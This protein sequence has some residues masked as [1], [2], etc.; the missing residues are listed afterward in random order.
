MTD[1]LE[2]VRKEVEK[3]K[4]NPYFVTAIRDVFG[5]YEDPVSEELEEEMENYIEA[6][7]DWS[8]DALRDPIKN[9][10]KSIARHFANWQKQQMILNAKLYGWVAR[11][12]NGRLHLF[13]VEPIRLEKEH[14]WWDRDYQSTAIDNKDFPDLKWED[15]PVYVKLPIIVEN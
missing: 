14:Q 6:H 7:M 11:D 10:G 15:E 2:Q 5:T 12:E 4:D 9:W 3:L 1:K 13:E 8:A